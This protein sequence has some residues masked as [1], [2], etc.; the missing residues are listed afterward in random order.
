MPLLLSCTNPACGRGTTVLDTA[1]V[2][3]VYGCPACR[4]P[5]PP[6]PDP[7]PAWVRRLRGPWGWYLV[8]R[9][10]LA[11]LW[12]YYGLS[13]LTDG[14]FPVAEL[15]CWS[16]ILY[17]PCRLGDRMS[18]LAQ[19]PPTAAGSGTND[20]AFRTSRPAASPWPSKNG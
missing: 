6:V 15:A 17:V 19:H 4:Q 12:V 3:A 16:V 18:C 9:L 8:A 10:A 14:V 13:Y 11:G 20:Q 5:L 2:G 7:T 1:P